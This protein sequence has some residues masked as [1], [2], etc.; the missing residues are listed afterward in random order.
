MLQGWMQG[1]CGACIQVFAPQPLCSVAPQHF[2]GNQQV[3][4][5]KSAVMSSHPA[6]S[7]FVSPCSTKPIK[8]FWFF[9]LAPELDFFIFWDFRD[10]PSEILAHLECL[11]SEYFFLYRSILKCRRPGMI[12]FQKIPKTTKI[13]KKVGI[14]QWTRPYGDTCHLILRLRTD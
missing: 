2:V 6:L 3:P 8:P 11:S 9:G 4:K 5:A 12:E 1:S 10:L 7:S 13:H 14:V